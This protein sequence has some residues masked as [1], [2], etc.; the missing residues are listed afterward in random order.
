MT[1]FCRHRCNQKSKLSCDRGFS[2]Q[3]PAQQPAHANVQREILN[4]VQFRHSVSALI[5]YNSASAKIKIKGNELNMVRTN[6]MNSN[7]AAL[8]TMK[9]VQ[10]L[11][12]LF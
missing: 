12:C 9:T 11:V 2:P 8:L 7:A 4:T 3:F 1:L 10:K 5:I 6:K